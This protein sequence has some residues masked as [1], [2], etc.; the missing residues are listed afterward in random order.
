MRERNVLRIIALLIILAISFSL[1]VCSGSGGGKLIN[2]AS[3]LKE[4]LDRQPANSPDNPIRVRMNVTNMMLEDIGNA[5]RDAGKYV[6]LDLSGSTGLT[7]IGYRAFSGCIGLTGISLPNS[8]T[9]I[10]DYAFQNTSIASIILPESL[11]EIGESAFA[12]TGL[13]SIEIP[14]SVT[15][16]HNDAFRDCGLISI[17]IPKTNKISYIGSFAFGRI[18]VNTIIIPG[19]KTDN[20]LINGTWVGRR[21]FEYSYEY[22]FA[23]GKVSVRFWD[24][25]G[26]SFPSGEGTY[27]LIENFL[28]F[29]NNENIIT[30]TVGVYSISD[31]TLTMSTD[32]NRDRPTIFRRQ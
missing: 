27:L 28:F 3:D 11:I 15:N 29:V 12:R 22:S 1:T 21:S 30:G 32:V 8:V 9:I 6:S 13:T 4:Y 5:I 26:R 24:R 31:N 16:I 20:S 7:E 2:S 23:D 19:G 25:W 10:E 14:N 17:I 18:P